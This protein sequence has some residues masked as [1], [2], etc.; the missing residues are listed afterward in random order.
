MLGGE[1]W[2]S[3]NMT[4]YSVLKVFVG[5]VPRKPVEKDAPLNLPRLDTLCISG[6]TTSIIVP[7]VTMNNGRKW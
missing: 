4:I 6:K 3:T 7:V 2:L 5:K 1:H